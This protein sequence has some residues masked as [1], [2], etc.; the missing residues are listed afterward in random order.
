MQICLGHTHAHM[1]QRN[2][3]Q[4]DN[5]TAMLTTHYANCRSIILIKVQMQSSA[6]LTRVLQ[7]DD[8]PQMLRDVAHRRIGG[9]RLVRDVVP[10]VRVHH[11]LHQQV[12]R[13]QAANVVVAVALVEQD[14]RPPVVP[15]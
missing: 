12:A 5:P 15:G 6:T 4:I 14:G 11:G 3:V 1:H 7:T 2:S 13:V 8:T 10:P 9:K